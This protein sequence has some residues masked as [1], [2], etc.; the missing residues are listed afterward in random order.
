M[1]SNEHLLEVTLSDSENRLVFDALSQVQEVVVDAELDLYSDDFAKNYNDLRDSLGIGSL[2]LPKVVEDAADELKDEDSDKTILKIEN[3]PTD[4][5][6][7]PTPSELVY[8]S[9]KST[10]ISELGMLIFAHLLD[11]SPFALDTD[12]KGKFFRNIY[13][14][15]KNEVLQS[16]HSS[17]AELTPH[18]EHSC[19]TVNPEY[20]CLL[21]LRAPAVVNTKLYPMD[22]V[23][24]QLT[25]EE[26]ALLMEP[27]FVTL[28][29]HYLWDYDSSDSVPFPLAK[30]RANGKTEW[31]F[32]VEYTR[33]LKAEH[34]EAME[35]IAEKLEDAA[36]KV[37]IK[38]GT[39][40]IF[41][42]KR[43]MHAREAFDPKYDGTD[44][45][46]QRLIIGGDKSK[47]YYTLDEIWP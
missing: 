41:N 46:V 4:E 21:G 31:R 39:L 3:Y 16:S 25:E 43:V 15:K 1:G 45:W 12:N 27:E 32:D 6:L 18:T 20:V 5:Y 40:A 37:N 26:L 30:K 24:A 47:T 33:G 35:K 17:L 34:Q 7:G 38:A 44:R 14:V 42:N 2:V 28:L 19:Y 23:E 10:A 29:D 8:S 36:V 11:G 22:S 13:P 9:K